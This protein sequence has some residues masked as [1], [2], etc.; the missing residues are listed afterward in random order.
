MSELKNR[1]DQL[2]RAKL[3]TIVK[4]ENNYL[5]KDGEV[6]PALSLQSDKEDKSEKYALWYYSFHKF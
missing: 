6:S 3:Q 2:R 5:G 1:L 4:K